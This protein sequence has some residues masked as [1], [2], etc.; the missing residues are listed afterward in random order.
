MQSG[1]P[2]RLTIAAI[3]RA[4]GYRAMMQQHLDLLPSSA[5]TLAEVEE[6]PIAFAIRRI[7]W[8]SAQ[9][10]GRDRV[11]RR[12]ELARLSGVERLLSEVAVQKALDVAINK[13]RQSI[14]LQ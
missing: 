8:A 5:A 6:S 1:R 2:R 13:L 12:W 4:I 3:R 7:Q 10:Q 11:S 14:E 9:L